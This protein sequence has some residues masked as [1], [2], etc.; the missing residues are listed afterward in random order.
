MGASGKCQG[1]Q[2]EFGL[3]LFSLQEVMARAAS[4]DG[5]VRCLA[6]FNGRFLI[7]LMHYFVV[8]M[9][10]IISII[11][12]RRRVHDACAC[13]LYKAREPGL[14]GIFRRARALQK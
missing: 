11:T 14:H 3:T 10:R 8:S 7:G 9:R 5:V 2:E 1:T 13:H 4:S 6:A 12:N